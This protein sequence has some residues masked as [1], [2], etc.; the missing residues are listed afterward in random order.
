MEI[1]AETIRA[2]RQRLNESQDAFARRFGVDQ[3]TISVWETKG[4]PRK[5]AARPLIIRVFQDLNGITSPC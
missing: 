2:V 4:P 3:S 1:T 5:G